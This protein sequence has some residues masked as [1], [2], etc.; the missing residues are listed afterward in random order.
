MS[1]SWGA[2][3]GSFAGPYIYGLYSK[4]VTKAAAYAGLLSGL[5]T[6]IILFFALGTANS[7]LAASCAIVVPFIVIPIV[8]RFT[9]APNKTLLNKAFDKGGGVYK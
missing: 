5:G 3:S 6:E 8:S 9:A 4:R 1:L 2:V 7:P